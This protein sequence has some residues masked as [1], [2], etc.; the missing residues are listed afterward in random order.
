MGQYGILTDAIKRKSVAAN[1]EALTRKPRMLIGP[2][3]VGKTHLVYTLGEQVGLPVYKF[4]CTPQSTAADLIGGNAADPYGRQAL[5]WVPGPALMAMGYGLQNP[6]TGEQPPSGILLVDDLHL[7]VGSDAEAALFQILDT[8]PGGRITLPTGQIVTAPGPDQ[9]RVVA[10]A[11]GDIEQFPEPIRSR[12]GGSIVVNEPSSEMLA[13]LQPRALARV[14]YADYKRQQG[15]LL[16]YRHWLTLSELWRDVDLATGVMVATDSNPELAASVLQVL[17][18]QG[19][20]EAGQ[21]LETIAGAAP[22]GAPGGA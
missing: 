14:C 4:A 17:S 10:T 2:P 12:L 22:S 11:N 20:V 3:G 7:A 15:P 21:L 1:I 13:C 5:W 8:G 18:T 16:T 19:V 6:H 9:Y